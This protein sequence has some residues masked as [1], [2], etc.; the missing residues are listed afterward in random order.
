MHAGM[1]L[2]HLFPRKMAA[3]PRYCGQESEDLNSPKMSI[4]EIPQV[5]CY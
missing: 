1:L 2:Y 3:R 4:L 5:K